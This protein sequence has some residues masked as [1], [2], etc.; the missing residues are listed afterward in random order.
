MFPYI[1]QCYI[2]FL[3]FQL[4]HGKKYSYREVRASYDMVYPVTQTVPSLST[5][6]VE[7]Y[8]QRLQEMPPHDVFENLPPAFKQPL[9]DLFRYKSA[10][11]LY[12]IF[13]KLYN[14]KV[15]S[16][17][18]PYTMVSAD[19]KFFFE[20][21]EDCTQVYKIVNGTGFPGKTQRKVN[22]SYH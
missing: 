20:F 13:G 5:L 17:S 7:A 14:P 3:T 19:K 21:D 12:D 6:C 11:I 10:V 22:C 16:F 2:S 18:L 15:I 1:F 4:L 8:S 9:S